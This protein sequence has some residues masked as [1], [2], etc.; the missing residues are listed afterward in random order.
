[1][2]PAP[3]NVQAI[4]IVCLSY[5]VFSI[6]DV[7]SK[8]LGQ[9]YNVHQILIY[10]ASLGIIASGIWLQRTLGWRGFIPREKKRWHV[11]RAF[12]VAG[13]PISVISSLQYLPLADYYGISFCAPFLI[14]ILS[15][16]FTR[17]EI[18]PA[19]WSAV[20]AGFIGVLI[21]AGP[22]FDHVGIGLVFAFSAAICISLS[23][24][25]VRKIG[26]APRPYY[27]FFPFC[28][29]LLVNLIALPL[30]GEYRPPAPGDLW[31]FAILITFVITG[32]LGFA[33][34]HTRA[35]SAAVTAP[36][37]YTQIIWGVLF[38]WLVFGDF[39]AATTWTGLA[40]IIGAGLFSVW[41]ER[42]LSIRSI[43]GLSRPA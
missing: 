30:F 2:P 42:R 40:I 29:T 3:S 15:A 26:H 5:F 6:A 4:A 7:F 24:F 10:T 1:M 37:L 17:E 11:M 14:L 18:G 21:L 19:R 12:C 23:V 28:A 39:P 13:I 16:L 20:I 31:M 43:R 34:G 27:I 32:Q 22:K 35:T 25:T 41:R 36:F 33:I 38:G 9:D 8:I